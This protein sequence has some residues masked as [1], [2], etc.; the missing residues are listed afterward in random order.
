MQRLFYILILC[1]LVSTANGQTNRID[2]LNESILKAKSE[3]EKADLYYQ[4][5]EA[6]YS[7]N[8]DKGLEYAEKSLTTATQAGY[9]RGIAQAL[10][11]IGNYHY[12]KGDNLKSHGYYIKALNEIKN[13]KS[14]DYPVRTYL[15]L[16][17]LFRQQSYFDSAKIYLDKAETI[18]TNQEVGTLHASL[19]ASL[20]ILANHM[21]K[22]DTALKFLKKS[23]QIRNQLSDTVRLADTWRNIG[24]VYADLAMYDSAQYC[25]NQALKVIEHIND[26]EI[27]MLLSLSQGETSFARGNFNQAIT[28]YQNALEKIKANTYKRHYAYLLYKIGELYENQG[29]YHTAFDY[30][31]NA[32]KEF[33]SINARQDIALAYSQIGWCYNYQE[34]Y[35]QA[36]EYGNKSIAIA[37][38]IVD[39]ASIA[40]N[41]NLIGY[42]LLK[43]GKY[44]EAL[45]NFQE[46][47]IVRKKIKQWWGVP[48][49]LLNIALVNIEMGETKK[50][51]DFLFESLEMNKKIGNKGGIVFT[52]NE[53][54]LLYAKLRQFDKAEYYLN[55][56]K[57]LA[58]QIPLPTQLIVSY[59]NLIFL[60]ERKNDGQ[61]SIEY[62]RHYIELN[63]SLNNEIGSSRIAKADALYQLQKKANEIQLVNKEN[64][65]KEERINRQQVEIDFQQKTITIVTVSLI[66]LLI[67]IVIIYRLLKSKTKAE[68][69]LRMQN[70]EILEQKEEIQ[71]QSEELS[72][73]NYRLS[74]LNDELIE[75]NHEIEIQSDKIQEANVNLEKRVEERTNQLNVAYQELETF[76]YRTS[77]D[78]RRPL[79]TYL[80]LVEIAKVTVSDK[81]AIDLFEKVKETTVGLDNMLS[82]LQSISNIDFESQSGE[83]S[84][85]TIIAQC[86]EKHKIKIQSRGIKIMYDNADKTIRVNEHLFR[87]CLENV[88][89]NSVNFSSPLTPYIKI[90]TSITDVNV[91]VIIEDNGQGI[92]TTIQHKIFEMY[93]RGNDNSKG[94]GLGLYIAKRAVDKL[95]G[96]ITF[97]SRLNEGT[98]FKITVPNRR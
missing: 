51:F 78:F 40:Q 6:L 90:T 66:V 35:S 24:A 80:G 17:I 16:S 30:L 77:H 45:A 70:L 49:T 94:N 28:H 75:K 14:S 3:Q 5:A 71:T 36:I 53:L 37:S 15:R 56:G 92:S 96:T 85:N 61:K 67:L 79:T 2:F 88:I 23:L 11:S 7:F 59:K 47:L 91:V 34:N 21:A 65:L 76:F 32:I 84:L 54:G 87:T 27:Q 69:I 31:F 4:L 1:S 74:A 68:E 18:L 55:M 44:Q 20:G 12:Y 97:I 19:Y 33:E 50:A 22:N 25:Y 58:K 10:T 8:F 52:C 63:D 60:F 95:D 62:Y 86:F 89:E 42:A 98:S 26:P 57:T 41:K 13:S 29:A 48:Y 9:K 82:K 72:E 81:Q 38:L 64:E 46:A 83:F 39:S 73:S 43:T 93:F